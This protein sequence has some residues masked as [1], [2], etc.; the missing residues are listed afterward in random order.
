MSKSKYE[1]I[2]SKG[3]TIMLFGK[4]GLGKTFLGCTCENSYLADF[5]K[6]LH[7]S[8][9]NTDYD[10]PE[11]WEWFATKYQNELKTK[12]TIIIDTVGSQIKAIDKG[13]KLNVKLANNNLQ[14][15]GKILEIESDFIE[16]LNNSGKNVIFI[17]HEQTVQ[18]GDINFAKPD[19]MG[20]SNDN[21]INLCSHVGWLHIND[22][23]TVSL[24]FNNTLY[25][26]GKNASNM[27]NI[28]IP[29][30]K[31]PFEGI[32]YL[33]GIL[34]EM[35]E[36]LNN[37]QIEKATKMKL[38]NDFRAKILTAKDLND[39]EKTA[40]ELKNKEI[41]NDVKIALQKIYKTKQD[42]FKTNTSI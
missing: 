4:G 14:R 13:L 20:K 6:G 42:L 7:R 24:S 1:P 39:L 12:D 22:N 16:T 28:V 2:I 27:D 34:N 29:R 40:E 9:L 15:F 36:R 23:N 32:G 26:Q 21:I 3:I 5:D 35:K 19:I 33:D 31:S 37:R 30:F 10:I 8:E 11:S 17:A 38:F 25:N 41:T 18:N